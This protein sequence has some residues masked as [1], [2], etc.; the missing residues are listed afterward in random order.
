MNVDN[1][2]NRVIKY[3]EESAWHDFENVYIDK[4]DNG[5]IFYFTFFLEWC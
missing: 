5:T 1:V 4:I 3:T 2:I